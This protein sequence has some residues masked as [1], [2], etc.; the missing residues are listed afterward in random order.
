MTGIQSSENNLRLSKRKQIKGSL[1]G[2]A[3]NST[4][5]R[6]QG[7][8]RERPHDGSFSRDQQPPLLIM[9]T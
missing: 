1:L 3:E 8:G 7:P 6:A 5:F 2:P 4:T 9:Q